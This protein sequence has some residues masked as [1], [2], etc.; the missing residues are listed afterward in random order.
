M[1]KATLPFGI[2]GFNFSIKVL[3]IMES[4]IKLMRFINEKENKSEKAFL[5][6]LISAKNIDLK[7]LL[8]KEKRDTDLLFEIDKSKSIYALLCMNTKLDGGYVFGERIFRTI[9]LDGGDE[10]FCV[11]VDVRSKDYEIDKILFETVDT[12]LNAKKENRIDEMIFK[13]I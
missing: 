8:D 12:Y 5:I 4:S 3:N 1:R 6:I 2:D 9:K 10:I 7:N 13:T 11:E